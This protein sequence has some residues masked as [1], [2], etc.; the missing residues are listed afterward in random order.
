MRHTVLLVDDDPRIL[1][2]LKRVFHREPYDVLVASGGEPALRVLAVRPVDVVVS[3]EDMPGMSGMEFL[4]QVRAQYPETTR[5]VLT[6]HACFEVAM[7]AINQGEVYRFFTKPCNAAE[8]GAAIREALQ[9][10]DLFA[11]SRRLL[12]TVRRQSAFMEELERTVPGIS[13]VTRDQTGAIVIDEA[14]I[15][16]DLAALLAEVEAELDAADA[17]LLERQSASSPA[18]KAITGSQRRRQT[19]SF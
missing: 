8:I 7:R 3:D 19:D 12:H 17:R 9:Q 13:C 5:M 11:K 10:K 4:G 2:A 1:Q 14:R 6:G 18:S 15:P 16:T